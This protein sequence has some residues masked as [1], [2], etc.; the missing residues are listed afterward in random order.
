M[1][2]K[3]VFLPGIFSTHRFTY[4]GSQR[5][6]TISQACSEFFSLARRKRWRKISK[7]SDTF[8]QKIQIQEDDPSKP[9]G[10]NQTVVEGRGIGGK[11]V[12]ME[13]APWPFLWSD[14]YFS[15]IQ[16]TR[17]C[18]LFLENFPDDY[19]SLYNKSL[20]YL[21]RILEVQIVRQVNLST[22]GIRV[23]YG[24]QILQLILSFCYLLKIFISIV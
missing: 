18:L 8:P 13:K 14:L 5:P 22:R 21:M 1:A 6:T 16:F 15:V 23:S 12:P 10:D 11:P 9:S 19:R 2:G 4:F 7:E 24:I 3:G 20:F 17:S